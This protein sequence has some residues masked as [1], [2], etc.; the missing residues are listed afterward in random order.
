MNDRPHIATG[1]VG[2]LLVA[3]CCAAPL[4]VVALGSASLTAWLAN[5]NYVLVPAVLVLLAL[6]VLLLY[7]RRTGRKIMA[8]PNTNE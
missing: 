2:A 1:V 8:D 5:A 7:R 4:L 3:I 6:G